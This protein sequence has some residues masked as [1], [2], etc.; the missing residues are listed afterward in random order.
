MIKSALENKLDGFYNSQEWQNIPTEELI[1]KVADK[2]INFELMFNG[3]LYSFKHPS[4]LQDIKKFKK[5]RIKAAGIF[6]NDYYKRYIK[7]LITEKTCKRIGS[8]RGCDNCEHWEDKREARELLDRIL[9][10]HRF[11]GIS[12]KV[13]LPT[14]SAEE[15]QCFPVNHLSDEEKMVSLKLDSLLNVLIPECTK[16][17][18]YNE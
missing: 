18:C 4:C 8:R 3:K 10:L 15:P 9:L 16:A 1:D 7:A 11:E 17:G 5:Q 6:V 12:T 14:T 2:L 13:Y